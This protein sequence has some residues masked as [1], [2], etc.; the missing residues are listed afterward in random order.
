VFQDFGSVFAY[1]YLCN[2]ETAG[3]RKLVVEQL[4]THLKRDFVQWHLG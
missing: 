1:Q 3:E 2:T 4:G